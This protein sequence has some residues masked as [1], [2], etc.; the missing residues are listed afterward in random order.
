MYI[1]I[2]VFDYS[3]QN[4]IKVIYLSIFYI[5]ITIDLMLLY[6]IYLYIYIFILLSYSL[7]YNTKT[8]NKFN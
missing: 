1:I 8:I 7:Y 5:Y 4:Y 3:N 2:Q 6:I